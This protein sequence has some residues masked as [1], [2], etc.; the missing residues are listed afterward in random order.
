[1]FKKT[2]YRWIVL[3]GMVAMLLNGCGAPKEAPA[4]AT[5]AATA[6]A[7]AEELPLELEVE[8]VQALYAAGEVVIVDVREDSEYKAGH[9]PGAQLIPLGELPDRLNDVP[10]DETVVLVCRSGNR[11]AQAHQFLLD[12]GFT[13]VHNMKGGMNDWTAAGYETEK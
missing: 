2:S 11:S 3:L 10:R 9:I 12:Q 8:E 7:Q 6:A 5:P 13:N 4:E 1:M